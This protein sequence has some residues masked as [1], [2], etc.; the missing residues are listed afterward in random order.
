[1]SDPQAVKLLDALEFRVHAASSASGSQELS[2][3]QYMKIK[4]LRL[5]LGGQIV[6][7]FNDDDDE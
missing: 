1:M 7:D 6:G 5:R 2:S 4:D 3:R